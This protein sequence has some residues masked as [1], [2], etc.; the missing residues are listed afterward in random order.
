M[1]Q[2]D[3][4]SIPSVPL[5]VGIDVAKSTLEVAIGLVEPTLALSNDEQGF[6]TLLERLRG[7]R[8]SLI[9]LEA[10]GGLEAAVAAVCQA[11]GFDV[12]VINPR[13]ARDFARAMGRLAKTD[14]I[15]A[16]TLAHLAQIIDAHERRSTFVKSMPNEQQKLL[17][18]LVAR[19]R[20]IV[21]MLVAEKNRLALAHPT[22]Q[23]SIKT[24]IKALDKE[25][26]RI[27]TDISSYTKS[28]FADITA[29]LEGVKG[30]GT[31]TAATLAAELP[32][33]GKLTRREISALVG[34]APVNRDSGTM[35]GK[36][37]IFAGRA[38]VRHALYMATLVATRFNPVIK[39]FYQRLVAAGKPKKLALV[40]CM[41]KLLTALNAMVRDGKSWDDS[42]H[43]TEVKMA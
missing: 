5:T 28:H 15:D 37:T 3:T 31:T 32:E 8:V 33:L 39:A 34:V 12:A 20:Q 9:L 16:R 17:A 27:D 13:Q 23:K 38:S 42:F 21:G 4:I 40:A 35:R 26:E 24:I 19:R 29:L 1:S 18:A 10:T 11:E 43:T 2:P 36:R 41:R 25:L 7:Q 6:S 14:S 30:I 22:A